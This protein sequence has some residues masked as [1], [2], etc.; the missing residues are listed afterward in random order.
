MQ[1]ISLSK[2]SVFILFIVVLNL[3]ILFFGFGYFIGCYEQ[4]TVNKSLLQE[5]PDVNCGSNIL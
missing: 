3:F 5:I 4:I 2:K 1:V